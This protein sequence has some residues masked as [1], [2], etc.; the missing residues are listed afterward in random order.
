[1]EVVSDLSFT[2]NVDDIINDISER[3]CGHAAGY[4]VHVPP[5]EAGLW[6]VGK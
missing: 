1:M 5:E 3:Q 6:M 2:S 4:P